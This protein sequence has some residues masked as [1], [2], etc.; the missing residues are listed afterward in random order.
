MKL[1]INTKKIG[2]LMVATAFVLSS[3]QFSC[4]RGKAEKTGEKVDEA[5]DDT[6]DAVKDGFDNDGPVENTGEK[7]DSLMD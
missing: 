5:I 1:G 3:L 7:V 2:F 4:S 6:K